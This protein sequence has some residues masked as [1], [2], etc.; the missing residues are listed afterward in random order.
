M[1]DPTQVYGVE[2]GGPDGGGGERTLVATG[3]RT[4]IRVNGPAL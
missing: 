1:D 2:G 3:R 4:L